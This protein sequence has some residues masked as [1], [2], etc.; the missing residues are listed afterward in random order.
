MIHKASVLDIFIT[1]CL[2]IFFLSCAD[3]NSPRP[4]AQKFLDAF[5]QRDFETAKKYSTRETIKLLQVYQRISKEKGVEL[6]AKTVE[7]TSEEIAGER[8]VVYF[9]EQG[10]D[11]EQ[12]LVLK[13]VQVDGENKKQWRVLLTKDDAGFRRDMKLTQSP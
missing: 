3:E 10:D 11:L 8:A 9:K 7:I 2:L 4:V 1:V 12:K 13:K 6:P 5:Q